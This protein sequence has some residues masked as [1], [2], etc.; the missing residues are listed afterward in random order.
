MKQIIVIALFIVLHQATALGQNGL[1]GEYGFISS[2]ALGPQPESEIRARVAV[3]ARDYGIREFMFYDWFADYSTPVRGDEWKDAFY[4]SHPVSLATI[5]SAIDE[6]HRQGGRAW[7]YVQAVGAEEGDL[8]SPAADIWK[9]RTGQGDW[10][11]HPP[12]EKARFPTYFP[13]E[14]WARFM[15]ERWAPTVKDLGFD[16]IHWDTLGPIAGDRGAETLGIH[17]FI[18][19]THGLLE[20]YELLQTMNFVELHWWDDALIKTYCAFPYVE[21]WF[22]DTERRYYDRMDAPAMQGI[23]GVIAMYPFVEKSADWTETDIIKARAG[24]ARKHN[25]V[26]VI[27]GDGE[28]R[29]RHEYWPDT[30]PLN[31]AERDFL[32]RHG[33][34][35]DSSR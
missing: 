16:G 21:V 7:A 8:E 32:R 18:R 9:L 33:T 12:G 24:E 34:V 35:F 26:Y 20:K 30:I 10:Y 19:T 25:L 6:V 29:M 14:A 13:N 31:E 15:V 4:R 23:R 17:A 22:H 11:W 27:V 1:T 28:R 3:M 5:R 2:S